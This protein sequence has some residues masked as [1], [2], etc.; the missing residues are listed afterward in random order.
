[1]QKTIL[2]SEAPA[3]RNKTAN[4]T[5]LLAQAPLHLLTTENNSQFRGFKH[6]LSKEKLTS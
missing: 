1:M 3:M 5:V 2:S 4:I 6:L